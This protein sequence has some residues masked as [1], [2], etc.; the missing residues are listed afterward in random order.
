MDAMRQGRHM[1]ARIILFLLV[2]LLFSVG[3]APT[4]QPADEEAAK[5]KEKDKSKPPNKD[6]KPIEEKKP[7]VPPEVFTDT[8]MMGPQFAT[9]FNPQMMGDFPGYF[10][11]K[12]LT[13]TG[14]QTT[15]T[16]VSI[17]DQV[18]NVSPNTPI[19]VTSFNHG[20]VSGQTVTISGVNGIP[21]A[22]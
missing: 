19:I 5:Q 8:A 3:P 22:T 16:T 12:F 20:L 13:F 4:A 14:T 1:N 18:A 11:Q 15:T 10:V 2:A 6:K 9:G 21:G 7:A 17:V